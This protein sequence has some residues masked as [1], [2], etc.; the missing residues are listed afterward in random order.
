MLLRTLTATS[1]L[2][3]A[4][5]LF[6]QAGQADPAFSA[7][8][9]GIVKRIV[10]LPDGGSYISGS[11]TEVNGTPRNKL[12]RLHANGALDSSFDPGTGPTGGTSALNDLL[13]L[14][15]GKL[16]VGGSFTGFD[17]TE[18][19]HLVRLNADGSVDDGFD[20]GAGPNGA[21]DALALTPD[22]SI[23]ITGYFSSV[24]G[25]P[26][27]RLARL[28]ADGG[29]DP[30]FDAG[31]LF[32]GLYAGLKRIAVRPTGEVLVIGGFT[33]NG[34]QKIVQLLPDGTLDPAFQPGGGADHG[35]HDALHDL[36]LAPD[37]K[38]YI[39]GDFNRYDGIPR[40]RMARVNP[41]GSLDASW[42]PGTGPSQGPVA[43]GPIP[44]TACALQPDGRLLVGGWFLQ[45][46]GQVQRQ[47]AC[48]QHNGDLDPLFDPGTGPAMP[49]G[50]FTEI[51]A[52]AMLADNDVLVGGDFT[53]YNGAPHHGL[54]KVRTHMLLGVDEPGS[55]P[56][57]LASDG[58]MLHL[59]LP[60]PAVQLQLLDATGRVVRE[61]ARTL[62]LPIGDLP[63]AMYV[64]RVVQHDGQARAVRWVKAS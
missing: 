61:R 28:A 14:P 42:D 45:F 9:N 12:A 33:I 58:R 48:M 37:G 35:Y 23:M 15:D 62:E 55:A 26:A 40:S 4:T 44:V 31:E 30:G 34:A 2:A 51:H 1:L 59:G 32:A 57:R 8:T 47:L 6:P 49:T 11:F 54:V 64:L 18:A 27:I 10:A 52:M 5:L 60:R 50:F 43:S 21:V 13:A 3:C 41:D 63:N 39:V 38:A 56:L 46:N 53:V 16:L 17:G 25:Q 22:G 7:G 19:N 20:A 24:D 29:L 36:A